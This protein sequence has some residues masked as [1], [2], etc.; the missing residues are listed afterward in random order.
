LVQWTLLNNLSELGQNLNFDI[1]SVI[2]QEI[3]TDYG[4]IDFVLA[5]SNNQHRIV[6]LETLLDNKSKLDFK[7]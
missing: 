5:N 3:T 1:S 2:G 6:E 7:H 4:R